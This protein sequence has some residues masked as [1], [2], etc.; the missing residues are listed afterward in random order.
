MSWRWLLIKRH[1]S[2]AHSRLAVRWMNRF[3]FLGLMFSVFAWVTILSVMSGMQGQI[4]DRVLENKPH[5]LWEGRPRP[6]AEAV[7]D[8]IESALGEEAVSLEVSLRSEVL[9]DYRV[10]STGRSRQSG[11]IVE[12][13]SKERAAEFFSLEAPNDIAISSELAQSLGVFVGAQL[14]VRSAWAIE[15]FPLTLNV[16]DI[17]PGGVADMGAP[18]YM[19]RSTLSDWLELKDS[20]SWISMRL[21]DPESARAVASRLEESMDLPFQTWQEADSALWYS[22]RLE[23]NVMSLAVIF[24]LILSTFALYM[25]VSVRLA[26]KLKE[27]A[28]L[29]ALGA[30]KRNLQS[31]FFI[32][33]LLRAFQGGVVGVGLSYGV[34][35]ALKNAVSLPDFYYSTSIPV[36]WSWTR[37]CLALG[38]LLVASWVSTYLPIKK[39]MGFSLSETLRG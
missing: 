35:W 33:S 38:V 7:R 30:S 20:Y 29:K 3:A 34:C 4:K 13:I 25:A 21:A 19:Q 2:G 12:G 11:A 22:L 17:Y 8:S 10:A 5:V 14:R 36:D 37:A 23:K 1:L 26:E 28:L 27:L 32:E 9:V 15:R 24:V 6:N 16:R 18:I 39:A 31:I